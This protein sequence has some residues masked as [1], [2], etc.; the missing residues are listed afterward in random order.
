M[1]RPW[2]VVCFLISLSAC[3]FDRPYANPDDG[4]NN[5]VYQFI[6]ADTMKPI[7][8]AYV[9]VRWEDEKSGACAKGELARSDA[10]GWVRMKG[11]PDSQI[12][13][14]SRMVPGYENLYF[15]YAVPDNQHVTAKFVLDER[16]R[17]EYPAWAANLTRLGYKDDRSPGPTTTRWTKVY[18]IK[19]F[20][21]LMGD[22]VMPQ[23]HYVRYRSLPPTS[24]LAIG[25]VDA[26]CDDASKNIGLSPSQVREAVTRKGVLFAQ[27][28]CDEKWDT[29]KSYQ[30]D[31]A[32][33]STFDLVATEAEG[34]RLKAFA[35]FRALLPDYPY[36]NVPGHRTFTKNER[37]K[38][39]AWVKPYVEKYQ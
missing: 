32:L 22:F 30:P 17:A 28:L 12:S 31:N 23:L 7:Q 1:K 18:P 3:A 9:G 16:T 15:D 6:D 24:A 14:I 35:E 33:D 19:G 10:K 8:G 20:V 2:A 27:M 34:G 38:F 37:L 39:C 4:D 26:S 13:G 5:V 11:P 25:G 21:D 29:A 36:L